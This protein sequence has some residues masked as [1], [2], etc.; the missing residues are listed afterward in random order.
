[1]LPSHT[2]GLGRKTGRYRGDWFCF[3]FKIRGVGVE[4]S[5]SEVE[6]RCPST[7][8]HPQVLG[9]WVWDFYLLVRW[10]LSLLG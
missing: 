1:M 8:L 9:T 2:A 6:G 10:A 3:L 5:A 4:P 7:T